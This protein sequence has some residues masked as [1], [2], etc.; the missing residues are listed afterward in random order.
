MSRLFGKRA[1]STAAPPKIH[2]LPRFPPRSFVADSGNNKIRA[3]TY[4]AGSW[5][6]VTIVGGG[7]TGTTPGFANGDGTSAAFNNPQGINTDST[8]ALFITDTGNSVI[9]VAVTNNPPPQGPFSVFIF[10]GGYYLALTT[11]YN[12]QS[13]SL[14]GSNFN[15]LLSNTGYISL[16]IG[17][18]RMATARGAGHEGR[19]V[20]PCLPTLPP[21]R[22]SCAGFA[23]FAVATAIF[24]FF[25]YVR[26]VKPE[27]RFVYYLVRVVDAPAACLRRSRASSHP[28]LAPTP[29]SPFLPR[30]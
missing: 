19:H 4:A 10:G 5:S 6:A 7:A 2:C 15:S 30:R 24:G 27:A 23:F 9:R 22:P 20:Q 21:P 13:Q 16:W 18:A 1:F 12:Q 17:E 14:A 29:P 11:L 8:G 26:N 25:S 3:L 28:M